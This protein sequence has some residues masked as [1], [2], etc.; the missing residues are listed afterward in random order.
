MSLARGK[1][2][3]SLRLCLVNDCGDHGTRHQ[4][5][6]G[7][8][9]LHLTLATASISDHCYDKRWRHSMEAHFRSAP[10]LGAVYDN[11][12]ND[13]EQQRWRVLALDHLRGAFSFRA[14]SHDN[15]D[16]DSDT[17][18]QLNASLSPTRLTL[19]LTTPS[20]MRVTSA[21]QEPFRPYL[22]LWAATDDDAT[23]YQQAAS[24]TALS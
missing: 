19:G 22:S 14:V 15:E 12:N 11:L 23:G 17:C 3:I 4:P 5:G 6:V 9:L 21:A 16:S 1:A 13:D 20:M 18:R 8:A 7:L 2:V 10:E 24:R